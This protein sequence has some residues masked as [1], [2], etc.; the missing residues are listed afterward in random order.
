MSGTAAE[1]AGNYVDP[2]I[3]VGTLIHNIELKAGRAARSSARPAAGAVRKRKDF[4]QVRLPSGE[5]V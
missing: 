1:I 4:A 2:N 5:F 3:P